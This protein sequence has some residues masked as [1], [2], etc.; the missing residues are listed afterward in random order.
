MHCVVGYEGC[1]ERHGHQVRPAEIVASKLT[2]SCMRCGREDRDCSLLDKPFRAT[3]ASFEPEEPRRELPEDVFGH[4]PTLTQARVDSHEAEALELLQS[5]FGSPVGPQEGAL[6]HQVP[7]VTA[8]QSSE[9]E[10]EWPLSAF[11]AICAPLDA[12]VQS[13][14][15]VR[16]VAD[17]LGSRRLH[18]NADD[19]FAFVDCLDYV[20]YIR[21][22]LL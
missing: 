15:I 19:L 10:H 14:H 18:H 3:G 17:A 20:S 16:Q 9:G 8:S 4:P 1:G 21:S 6:G 22:C 13:A 11:S 5:V 12:L 7:S 2:Y